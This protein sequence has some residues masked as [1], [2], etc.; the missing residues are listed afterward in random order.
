MV[1][2][3]ITNP[4]QLTILHKFWFALL[5][6]C[7]TQVYEVPLAAWNDIITPI[8]EHRLWVG[9]RLWEGTKYELP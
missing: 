6:E 8:L 3:E 9:T 5:A 7:S 4:L 2:R 1:A